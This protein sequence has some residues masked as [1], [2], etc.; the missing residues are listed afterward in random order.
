MKKPIIVFGSGRSN[1]NTSDAVKLIMEKMDATSIIDLAHYKI[2]DF[3]YHHENKHDDFLPLIKQ[4]IQ[5]ETIILATPVYWYTMSAVMKRFVDRLSDLLTINKDYGRL[6]RQKNLAVISSY[7]VHPEGKNGFESIFINTAKYLDMNYMGCYFHYAG[8]DESV[9]AKNS[10]LIDTFIKS[11]K[12]HA[13]KT[14]M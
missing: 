10:D 14:T 11:L 2:G 9:I 3:D 12:N 13:T 1:G 7:S 4:I 5:Y 6:L 8:D